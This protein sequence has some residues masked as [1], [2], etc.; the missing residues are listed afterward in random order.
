[1]CDSILWYQG[2]LCV[3][4]VDSLYERI[5]TEAHF[6]G[7]NVSP[8]STK[9]YQDLREIFLWNEMKSDITNFVAQYSSQQVKVDHL[10]CCGISQDIAIIA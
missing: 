3:S 7:Y 4:D 5:S 10:R 8:N 1:M 6:L 2:R 9:M